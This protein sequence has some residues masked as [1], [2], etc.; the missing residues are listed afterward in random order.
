M[1]DTEY[2]RQV[3]SFSGLFVYCGAKNWGRCVEEE[4][5]QEYL[6]EVSKILQGELKQNYVEGCF[7]NTL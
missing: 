4:M 1:K 5:W 7:L 3:A 6:G 2:A